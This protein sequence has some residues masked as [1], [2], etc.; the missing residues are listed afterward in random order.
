VMHLWCRIIC[1]HTAI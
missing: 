1:H